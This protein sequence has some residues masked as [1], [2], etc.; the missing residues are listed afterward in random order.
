M[1]ARAHKSNEGKDKDRPGK[2]IRPQVAHPLS[3]LQQIVGN[4]TVTNMI[5]RHGGNN[6]LNYDFRIRPQSGGGPLWLRGEG[7]ELG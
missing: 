2:K 1:K 6:Y 4:K 5:Q 3:Q 7:Q